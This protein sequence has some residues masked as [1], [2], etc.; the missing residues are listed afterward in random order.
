MTTLK[1]NLLALSHFA[2]QRLRARVEGLTD[3]EYFWEP[4]AGSWSVRETADGFKADFSPLPPD[5]P[6]FT[7]IAWR[8]THIIDILQ[9]ERTATWFGHEPAPTDGIPPVPGSSAEA[10]KAM[11]HAYAVWHDRLDSLSQ[12][13]LDRP[14]GTVAGPYAADDGTSFALHIL[15]ELIHH[16]AEVGVVRDVYAGEQTEADPVVAALLQGDRAESVSADV[17]DRVRQ[18]RPAL[19]AEAVGAQR[20]AAVPLLIELGF[21]VNART[22]SGASPAHIAA[23]AGHLSVLRLLAEHGA[24]LS[25]TD[26]QFQATPLGWAQWFKQP[27]TADFLAAR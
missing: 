8:M 27:E 24:D 14:M 17:L 26:P 9:A 7:T 15:D 2:W 21:D 5:P 11:E 6:P 18:Q 4:F 19:I 12:E 20:W 1:Q 13:D 3:D 23:G 25:A 22:T 16:G 10:I